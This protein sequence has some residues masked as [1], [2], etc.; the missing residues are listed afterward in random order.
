MDRM[1]AFLENR[2]NFLHIW[3]RDLLVDYMIIR[4]KWCSPPHIIGGD[5]QGETSDGMCRLAFLET[6][7]LAGLLTEQE[8]RELKKLK[9][10]N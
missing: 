4:C 8:K 2:D 1:P 9:R 10:R 3:S 6:C 7:L 5:G